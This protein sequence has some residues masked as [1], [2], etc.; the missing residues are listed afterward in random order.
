MQVSF[1]TY[2]KNHSITEPRMV[3]KLFVTLFLDH[4]EYRSL[5]STRLLDLYIN[6]EE[7]AVLDYH[8]VSL[9]Y[10]RNESKEKPL[11][12]LIKLFEFVISPF[13]R[14]ING[15]IYTPKPIRNVII[16]QCLDGYTPSQLHTIRVCDIACGCGGFLMDVAEYIHSK[17]GKTFKAIFKDNIF[18]IDIQDYSVERTKILLSLLALTHGEDEAFNF[19]IIQADTLDFH[20]DM[21]DQDFTSFDVIVG[22][23][24][25]V[26]SRNVIDETKEKM[27]RYEVAR[28]G[29]PDLYIPFFQIADEMLKD[30]GR[31]GYITMNS[32]L[33]SIN[34]RKLRQYFS[35]QQKD[36]SIVDFRGYQIFNKKSTYTCLFFLNKGI[37]ANG[38]KYVTD[39]QGS[40][41]S[42]FAYNVITYSSLDDKKGWN[43]NDNSEAERFE[44]IGTPIGKFCAS[45]HGIATLS[46]KTYIF[47]PKSED[48][49]YFFI[50]LDGIKYSIEKPICRDIVN[51]NKLNSDV[52]FTSVIEKIV[53]PYRKDQN[54]KIK[55]IDERMMQTDY[56][57]AYRYLK[58]KRDE[59]AKRDKGNTTGYPVWY[60]YGR[61]Q[62]LQ[63]P[64]YKLFFPKFANRE[65]RCVLNDDPDL[66]LYN[67]LAF[68]SDDKNRLRIIQ[69]I[70]ESSLFWT[71][72]VKNS[73][74]YSSDYYSLSGVDIKNF[75]IPD[76]STEEI[77]HL[78]TLE[79]KV[80]IDNWLVKFYKY[81]TT[82]SPL[83]SEGE[84]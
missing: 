17:T 82:Q 52:D 68:V 35:N 12:Y 24:P 7:K 37:I 23:P 15:A 60:A 34:G 53:Y 46:N 29:H 33:R 70:I 27:L 3:N 18:G 84:D 30:G 1:L 74:P 38:V 59:L 55:V 20:S 48:D 13:D 64:R 40:L 76:F 25:Y 67:G 75:G 36:I 16:E 4:L 78:L 45:R 14:I 39:E 9:Y 28:S 21:W 71:Y 44:S 54:G 19:N 26:C 62:S 81:N 42:P 31:L 2:F 65:I 61:T 6:Q 72:I 69:K 41:N 57:G 56:P 10:Q 8:S 79:S 49:F 83:S 73:K 58:S 50:E 51:S 32:F 47:T 80:E 77:D 66:L 63:M 5:N 22:N 11:E 43:L